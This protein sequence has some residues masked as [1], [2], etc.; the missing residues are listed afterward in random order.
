MEVNMKEYRAI[1][2]LDKIAV[3]KHARIWLLEETV[4]QAKKI[5]QEIAIH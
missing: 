2:N 3:T 5:M 4:E 1:N